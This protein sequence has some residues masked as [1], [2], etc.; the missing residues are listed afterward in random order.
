MVASRIAPAVT[1]YCVH[2]R[3]HGH[4]RARRGARA[5]SSVAALLELGIESIDGTGATLAWP[6]VRSAAA[7]LTEVADGEDAGPTLPAG[8]D[9]SLTQRAQR[10]RRRELCRGA[11]ATA[12]RL[13]RRAVGGAGRPARRR[14][15]DAAHAARGRRRGRRLLASTSRRAACRW[16][17]RRA[18]R[19]LEHERSSRRWPGRSA[20]R[21]QAHRMQ[22]QIAVDMRADRETARA[23]LPS[24]GDQ[25]DAEP[26]AARLA[27]RRHHAEQLEARRRLGR[28]GRG[29]RRAGGAP[30]SRDRSPRAA[31]ES[32]TG[33]RVRAA[34]AGRAARRSAQNTA[35][36]ATRAQI[37]NAESR[38]EH[39]AI[40]IQRPFPPGRHRG[41]I[42]RI[43]G[44]HRPPFAHDHNDL[45]TACAR[46]RA[47]SP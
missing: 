9:R 20:A 36:A 32:P 31:S 30:S 24:I 37:T 45:P 21:A 41:P 23:G 40:I 18:R 29:R 13:R 47:A 33:D 35:L 28:R 46:A 15:G 8:A 2:C 3:S 14:R 7:L 26:A 27:Q 43:P 12:R 4:R 22:H 25:R 17:A 11:P 19:Q 1:D 34:R 44:R 6:L 5:C 10:D 42:A 39:A 38:A 16:P